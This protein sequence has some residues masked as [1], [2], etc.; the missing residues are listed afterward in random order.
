VLR[1][2]GVRGEVVI[3]S[4]SEHEE[5]FAPGAAFLRDGGGPLELA[6]ARRHQGRLLARFEGIDDRDRAE[7]L[8]GVVLLVR[9]GEVPPAPRGSYYHFELVGCCVVDRR[10]GELGMVEEVVEDGGGA[11][12]RV[13][14]MGSD[15][16][17]PFVGAFLVEVD[18]A[19]RRIEVDLPEGLVEAC[20]STS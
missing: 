7:S 12:L 4:W 2:H 14:A 19:S 5:R 6:A 18:I 13:R 9:R 11:L 16:L 10:L 8:R 1:P 20:A 15:L 3:E 17:V